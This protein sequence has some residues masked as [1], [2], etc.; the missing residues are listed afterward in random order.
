VASERRV[1]CDVE[2]A[3]T[4]SDDEWADLLGPDG[5]A[6]ARLLASGRGESLSLAATRVW[7]AI[8]CLRKTG[9]ATTT[10][11]DASGPEPG[12]WVVL[13]SGGARIASFTT[14]LHGVTEP[15]VFTMLAEGG[16]AE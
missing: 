10:L 11:A 2:L 3:A 8:E 12:R 14:S 13:G 16:E 5:L 9:H 15:V 6:L 1:A 4:R 7:G